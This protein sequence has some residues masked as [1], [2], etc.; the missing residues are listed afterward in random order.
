MARWMLRVVS[1]CE[2]GVSGVGGLS[3]VGVREERVS[4]VRGG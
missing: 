2:R 3:E 1:W 4:G